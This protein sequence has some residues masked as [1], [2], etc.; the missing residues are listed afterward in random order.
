MV[1]VAVWSA[2]RDRTPRR[3]MATPPHTEA[4]LEEWIRADPSLVRDGL[5]VVAQQLVFPTKE[6]LDLLCVEN[7][8]RW[9]VVELKKDRMAREVTAQALDYVSLLGNMSTDDLTSRLEPHLQLL[10]ED[11]RVLVRELLASEDPENPREIS[12]VVVGTSADEPLLR[13]TRYLSEQY[14]VPLAVVELQAFQSPSGDLLI[15]REETGTDGTGEAGAES[16]P[17]GATEEERWARVQT[18]AEESGFGGAL[19]EFRRILQN[20]PVYL[21][22]YTRSVMLAPPTNRTRYLGVVGFARRKGQQG[23]ADLSYGAAELVGFYPSLDP[24]GVGEVLGPVKMEVTPDE[25]VAFARRLAG[26]LATVET[27]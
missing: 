25:L 2:P 17:R 18:Y 10:S 19:R 7:R 22:P 23:T 12:A 4:A 5:V 11:N 24:G 3:L 9:L 20:T 1:S 16:A 6:R 13:I 15:V 21:R 14:N 26:L 8:S 27:T